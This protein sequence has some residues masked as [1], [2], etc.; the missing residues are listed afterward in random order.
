M[1]AL[2]FS[3]GQI[4]MPTLL[5][6]GQQALFSIAGTPGYATEFESKQQVVS[7]G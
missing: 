2:E 1:E 5:G 4:V 7:T 6:E 3:D